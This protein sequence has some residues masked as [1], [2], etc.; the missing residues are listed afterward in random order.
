MQH[1]GG[2]SALGDIGAKI[3]SVL[4]KFP[5]LSVRTIVDFLSI[6]VSTIYTHL[7]EKIDLNFFTSLGSPHI[8]Q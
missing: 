4:R 7:V 2:Q 5:F 1:F 8:N 3:I 6:S